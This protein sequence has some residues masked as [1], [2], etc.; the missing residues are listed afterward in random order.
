[1][2]SVEVSMEDQIASVQPEVHE[3][4]SLVSVS[5][6]G[7]LEDLRRALRGLASAPR[8]V[9][10]VSA[11]IDDASFGSV[12]DLEE[13]VALLMGAVARATKVGREAWSGVQAA[14]DAHEQANASVREAQRRK[15]DRMAASFRE[16]QEGDVTD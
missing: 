10:F 1:M 9:R 14:L 11:E 5:V 16:G 7:A 4:L 8:N 15:I 2:G 12:A 13:Q 6:Y 3:R